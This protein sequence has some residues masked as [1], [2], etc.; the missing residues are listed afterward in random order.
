M[1]K[2]MLVCVVIGTMSAEG[3]NSQRKRNTGSYAGSSAGGYAGASAGGGYGGGF[4]GGGGYGGGFGGG[5]DYG[6]GDYGYAPDFGA[7][8][9]DPYQFH[10]QLTAQI[11]ANQAANN[12]RIQQ[13]IAAQQS[14]FDN[15]RHQNHYNNNKGYK[16]HRYAPSYAAASGSIGPGGYTQTAFINPE[17]PAIPNISNRF[18]GGSSGGPGGYQ[19]VSVSSFATSADVN[20]KKTGSRGAQTTINDNGKVTTYRVHN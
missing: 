11:Y 5:N 18:G 2:F 19:G 13:Q 6:Y 10:Q 15:V 20:G 4:G 1:W 8:F 7:G 12:N 9:I 3:A 14:F 16:P 17:N